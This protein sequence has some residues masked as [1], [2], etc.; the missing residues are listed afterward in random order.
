MTFSR[1]FSTI[2]QIVFIFFLDEI[3]FSCEHFQFF[4]WL[5]LFHFPRRFRLRQKKSISFEQNSPNCTWFS[6]FNNDFDGISCVIFVLFS[7]S[8]L[9]TLPMSNWNTDES[10]LYS[11]SR[12]TTW[13]SSNCIWNLEATFENRLFGSFKFKI[14]WLIFNVASQKRWFINLSH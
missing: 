7:S 9:E 12:Y 10:V 1:N 3:C 4:S 2:L 13:F 5:F 14:N 11:I 6:A 8:S